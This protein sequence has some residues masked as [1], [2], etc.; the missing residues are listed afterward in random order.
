MEQ[1][2]VLRYVLV[3]RY[4]G[5]FLIFLVPGIFSLTTVSLWSYYH[6][7]ISQ[8][9]GELSKG[10]N[11]ILFAVMGLIGLPYGKL[12]E[13]TFEG[14]MKKFNAIK[15][16]CVSGKENECEEFKKENAIH[17]DPLTHATLACQSIGV[18]IL[19]SLICYDNMFIGQVILSIWTYTICLMLIL[20][21]EYDNPTSG[22][23]MV[24]VP[25]EWSKK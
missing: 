17:I 2:M 3:P 1:V 25:K 20:A 7:Y 22:V 16:L 5:Y 15:R 11:I 23:W 6:D 21:N 14:A 18:T 10:D 9:T 8:I 4:V 24:N 12:A 13:K 19:M